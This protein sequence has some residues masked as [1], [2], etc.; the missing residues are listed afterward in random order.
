VRLETGIAGIAEG[1]RTVFVQ[2]Q[3][4]G[5]I[6]RIIGF[7]PFQGSRVSPVLPELLKLPAS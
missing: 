4:S 3:I 5:V 6:V 7:T 2:D 1:G